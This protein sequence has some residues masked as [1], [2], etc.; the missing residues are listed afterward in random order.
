MIGPARI[1]EEVHDRPVP[2]GPIRSS[3]AFAH[4]FPT[5]LDSSRQSTQGRTLRID[6]FV[7]S[8]AI[9]GTNSTSPPAAADKEAPSNRSTTGMSSDPKVSRAGRPGW[10]MGSRSG[11]STGPKRSQAVNRRASCRHRWWMAVPSNGRHRAS[12]LPSEEG[13]HETRVGSHQQQSGC[14]QY[15]R[16]DCVCLRRGT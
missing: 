8:S 2:A 11:S 14:A 3:V 13:A 1:Y 10:R 12:L 9:V 16:D 4:F 7:P 5:V 15:G 6:S